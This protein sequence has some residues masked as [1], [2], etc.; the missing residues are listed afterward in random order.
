MSHEKINSR[1]ISVPVKYK[2]EDRRFIKVV[3][4]IIVMPATNAVSERSFSAMRRL[5]TYLRSSMSK[6]R[7]NNSMVLHIHKEEHL[8]TMSLIDIANDFVKDSD[9][10]M[11]VFG[12]FHQSDMPTCLPA[13]TKSI[14]IQ[15]DMKYRVF[16]ID[17]NAKWSYGRTVHFID[18]R[19][20]AN[21]SY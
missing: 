19:S 20:F 9:H 21:C 2:K 6:N 11:Y 18:M 12:Q 15:V 17:T 14:G 1:E 4:L 5:L 7:L 3:K 8:D 10:R 13:L 16:F